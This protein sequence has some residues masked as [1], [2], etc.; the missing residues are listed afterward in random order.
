LDK[1]AFAVR[2][3][4]P[5][6]AGDE[7]FLPLALHPRSQLMMNGNLLFQN[8][9][10]RD[11]YTKA[12]EMILDEIRQFRRRKRDTKTAT[13]KAREIEANLDL[14]YKTAQTLNP[15]VAKFLPL[16]KPE[17]DRWIQ[18]PPTIESIGLD[19]MDNK[20]V[21]ALAI[22]AQCLSYVTTAA[23]E[24]TAE[25]P[26]IVITT[27]EI[28]AGAVVMPVPLLLL[29]I[30]MRE[31]S[32]NVNAET[33]Q[34]LIPNPDTTNTADNAKGNINPPNHL[35]RSHC[36]G[37]KDL[38]MLL[39]CPLSIASK[40][41]IVVDD[42]SIDDQANTPNV[43]LRWNGF[44]SHNKKSHALPVEQVASVSLLFCITAVIRKLF[45]ANKV[46]T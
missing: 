32:C 42:D 38:P 22:N 30:T 46:L 39:L 4:R 41:T 33:G 24:I 34:C 15:V 7:L 3:S 36:W 40:M 11:D 26:S 44:N 35:S 16:K 10:T 1:T 37:H 27:K 2:A 18:S 19:A 9:P 8:I 25:A 5:I 14:I 13:A 29:S 28:S 6:H 20:T 12:A 21:N 45:F 43:E 23:T 17:L 31:E